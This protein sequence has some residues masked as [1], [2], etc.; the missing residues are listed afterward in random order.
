[1]QT[2]ST[3]I[4]FYNTKRVSYHKIYPVKLDKS[5]KNRVRHICLTL[6]LAD[7]WKYSNNLARLGYCLV[8]YN[9][10]LEVARNPQHWPGARTAY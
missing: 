7:L 8:K 9:N 1:M 10:T 3:I 5:A 6:F 4:N 2:I